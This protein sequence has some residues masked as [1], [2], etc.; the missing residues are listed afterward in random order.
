[1]KTRKDCFFGLHFDFHAMEGEEIG[2]IIDTDSIEKMLDATKPDMIQVDTK[3]HP[4]ISSYMT[5]AGVH[6]EVMNMDVLKVW[7]E[8]TAKRGIRLYAH[9]SGLFDIMQTKLHPEW[10]SLNAEGNPNGGSVNSG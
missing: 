7:R 9:H 2:S 8:L 5:E 3:G 6:A 1:M 4:G 10:R